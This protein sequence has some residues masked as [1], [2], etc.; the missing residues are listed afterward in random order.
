M[1]SHSAAVWPLFSRV[2]WHSVTLPS[3]LRWMGSRFYVEASCNQG[4]RLKVPQL[5]FARLVQYSV[6]MPERGTNGARISRPLSFIEPAAD[7]QD[8]SGLGDDERPQRGPFCAESPT[9]RI[10]PQ[11][12]R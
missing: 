10:P 3:L 6:S 4:L 5:L 8:L 7:R 9:G 2:R 12:R 1:W 11:P